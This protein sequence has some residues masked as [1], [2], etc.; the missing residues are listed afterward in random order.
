MSKYIETYSSTLIRF[1]EPFAYINLTNFGEGRGLMQIH[2]DWGSYSYYWGS[3]GDSI[4][5]FLAKTDASYIHSKLQ[6]CVNYQEMKK[7]AKAKLARFM[8]QSW[9][10]VL[11]H[12]KA[13]Q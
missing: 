5:K 7:D 8:I 1:D 9:P 6:S 13:L 4:E 12:L 2:S 3:M 10:A 11:E